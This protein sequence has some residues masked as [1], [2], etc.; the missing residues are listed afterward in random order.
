[1]KS[2]ADKTQSNS[3]WTANDK[4]RVY[5]ALIALQGKITSM[6]FIN[7]NKRKTRRKLYV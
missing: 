6:K 3:Q 5:N 2:E 4:S 1:M 7:S